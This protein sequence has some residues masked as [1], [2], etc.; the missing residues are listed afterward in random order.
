MIVCWAR[1]YVFDVA[2]LNSQGFVNYVLFIF[3]EANPNGRSFHWR[4][5]CVVTLLFDAN[6][7]RKSL[8]MWPMSP[9]TATKPFASDY[10]SEVGI[11]IDHAEWMAKTNQIITFESFFNSASIEWLMFSVASVSWKRRVLVK[12]RGCRFVLRSFTVD[13]TLFMSQYIQLFSAK[14]HCFDS[15]RSVFRGCL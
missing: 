12:F 1:W 9:T 4:R 5:T 8:I 3:C 10:R 13:P 2:K 7:A 15:T 11:S 6:L 14:R